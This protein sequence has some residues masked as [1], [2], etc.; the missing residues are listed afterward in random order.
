MSNRTVNFMTYAHTF[1]LQYGVSQ[2]LSMR[3]RNN[4]VELFLFGF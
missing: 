4:K 3:A 1:E 2:T